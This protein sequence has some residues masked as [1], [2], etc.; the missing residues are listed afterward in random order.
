MITIY[1]CK[2]LGRR[3]GAPIR[4]AT[5]FVKAIAKQNIES[6]LSGRFNGFNS[7]IQEAKLIILDKPIRRAI[8]KFLGMNV[9]D[10]TVRI[11]GKLTS[12]MNETPKTQKYSDTITF[13]EL[14]D[15]AMNKSDSVFG[16]EGFDYH[17]SFLEKIDKALHGVAFSK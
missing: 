10:M 12:K 1:A 17:G 16:D 8:R 13:K 3:S 7:E 14:K 6:Q 11:K 2:Q 9:D 15:V 4:T 5:N